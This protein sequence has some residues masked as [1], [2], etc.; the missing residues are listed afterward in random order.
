ML[1]SCEECDQIYLNEQARRRKCSPSHKCN[2]AT[3]ILVYGEHS[4]ADASQQFCELIAIK[5]I[6]SKHD[7]LFFITNLTNYMRAHF[8]K[9][10]TVIEL[11]DFLYL[12]PEYINERHFITFFQM[13]T[14]IASPAG[15]LRIERFI[16]LPPNGDI[17]REM[18]SAYHLIN[19]I[20]GSYRI[21]EPERSSPCK[22]I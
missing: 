13:A 18:I 6:S 11:I 21:A 10:Y 4:T 12:V 15:L 1:G 16:N 7:E 17:V 9:K 8:D 14:S 20:D 5:M 3:N 19:Y 22:C 2:A